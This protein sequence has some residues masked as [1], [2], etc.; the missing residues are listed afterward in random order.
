MKLETKPMETKRLILRQFIVEDAEAM[1]RNY[2]S[3]PNVIRFVTWPIYPDVGAAEY[4][5]RYMVDG[6][7][8]GELTDWA[9]ELKELGQVIGSIGV[10]GVNEKVNSVEVGY[11]IGSRWWN[12]GITS[13]AFAAVI[14]Y[15]FEETEVQRIE[16]YHDPKNPGSGAVMRK[17]GLQ[18]EGTRRQASRNNSGICDLAGYAIL[19]SDYQKEHAL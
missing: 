17:C 12:Q 7:A 1:Y 6:Y 2:G 16:A 11:C 13:E 3:D 19:K 10:V 14:R 4:R 9:M 15:F 8:K 18:Y 5:M